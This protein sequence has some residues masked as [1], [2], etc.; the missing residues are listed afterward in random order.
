M[1][2]IAKPANGSAYIILTILFAMVLQQLPLPA[3]IAVARPEFVL[4]TLAY[5]SMAL[6]NRVGI[7]IAWFV[8]LL[9]DVLMGTPLGVNALAYALVVY[10]IVRFYLQLR[11][12]PYWQQAILIFALVLLTQLI[13]MLMNAKFD[14]RFLVLSAVVSAIFWPLIYFALRF[15]RR[16]FNVT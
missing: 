12:Y 10:V 11:Q 15:I 2:T 4:L 1:A 8:G 5:W 6:P 3:V 16:M 9:V 14:G 7:T 13:E